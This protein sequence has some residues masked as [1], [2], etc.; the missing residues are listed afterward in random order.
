MSRKYI[1]TY[2]TNN[3]DSVLRTCA[4][5]LDILLPSERLNSACPVQ[6]AYKYRLEQQ[7][8]AQDKNGLIL[9]LLRDTLDTASLATPSLAQLTITSLL[10]NRSLLAA[11]RF[12]ATDYMKLLSESLGIG[13]STSSESACHHVKLLLDRLLDPT[14]TLG[15]VFSHRLHLTS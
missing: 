15:N 10:S 7:K 14:N 1:N 11:L 12:Y 9:P 2:K 3:P 8:F 5:V 13:E 4:A 6:E